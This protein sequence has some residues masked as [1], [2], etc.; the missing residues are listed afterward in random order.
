MRKLE[1]RKNFGKTL[2]N[3]CHSDVLSN[4]R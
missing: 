1:N 4:K 3:Y 2:L